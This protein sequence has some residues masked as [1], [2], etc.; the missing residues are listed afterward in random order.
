[1]ARLHTFAA[2]DD[3]SGLSA[4]TWASL[5]AYALPRQQSSSPPWADWPGD[6]GLYRIGVVTGFD[7]DETLTL[8]S[9]AD[10]RDRILV[11]WC[12]RSQPGE[13]SASYTGPAHPGSDNDSLTRAA[14]ALAAS[15]IRYTGTGRADET[16][17]G[18]VAR[19]ADEYSLYADSTTGALKLHRDA[20]DAASDPDTAYLLIMASPQL[21][22]RSSPAAL[23]DISATDGTQIEPYQLNG[24]QDRALL[25]QMRE[26]A[27]A[28]TDCFPLGPKL[29][30][31]GVPE[32]WTVRGEPRRQPT[33]GMVTRF[34]YATAADGT[35]VVV[36]ASIDWRDRFVWIGAR[37][38]T[39]AIGPGGAAETSH[40]TATSFNTARYTG[41]GEDGALTLQGYSLQLD[42]TW[43][44]ATLQLRVRPSDG[45]LMLANETGSTQYV[46]GIVGASFQLGPRS[47][48]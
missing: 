35:E 29:D 46:T 11:T 4:A 41:P 27:S 36:D 38:S 10:W 13:W 2:G 20:D 47:S 18:Y 30:A 25:G 3:L 28:A 17:H 6:G 33:A 15:T 45:A 26:T 43:S 12:L 32:R 24:F 19:P 44:S 5:L 31:G 23:P 34:L 16:A 37:R 7:V 39:S 21:G 9:E 42:Q 1:M 40:N 8:D 22:Q 48:T 14:F